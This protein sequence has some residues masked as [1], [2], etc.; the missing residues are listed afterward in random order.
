MIKIKLQCT[1]LLPLQI[2]YNF[3]NVKLIFVLTLIL[4]TE[5]LIFNVLLQDVV[6]VIMY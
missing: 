6:L 4:H 3:D 2:H 5:I 1:K